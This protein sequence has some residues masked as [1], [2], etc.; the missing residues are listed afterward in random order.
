MS[1]IVRQHLYGTI[2]EERLVFETNWRETMY[3]VCLCLEPSQLCDKSWPGRPYLF[4]CLLVHISQ[5]VFGE[6]YLLRT[7]DA[8]SPL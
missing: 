4:C 5:M 2:K 6:C 1:A 3:C 8:A 7:K